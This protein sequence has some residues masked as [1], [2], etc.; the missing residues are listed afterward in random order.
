MV[1]WIKKDLDVSTLRYQ[2]VDDMV[3]AIGLPKEKLCLYCWTGE[4]PKQAC[5]KSTIDIVD[6]EKSPAKKLRETKIPL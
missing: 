2:D 3:Q 5:P 1:E 4:C 6:V